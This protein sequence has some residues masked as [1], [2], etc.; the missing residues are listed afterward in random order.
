MPPDIGNYQT[1]NER[2][3]FGSILRMVAFSDLERHF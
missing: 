1:L 3:E 2:I